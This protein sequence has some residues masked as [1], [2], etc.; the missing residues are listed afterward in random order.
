[1]MVS[2]FKIYV[3]NLMICN[4]V[5]RH[6]INN[7]FLH[8]GS[9]IASPV[10]IHKNCM[11]SILF[12][13]VIVTWSFSAFHRLFELKFWAIVRESD[14]GFGVCCQDA[15]DQILVTEFLWYKQMQDGLQIFLEEGCEDE[16]KRCLQFG[17]SF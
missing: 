9:S 11:A 16:G 13:E 1:M 17:Y 12:I 14:E 10:Y 8:E 15:I 4:F 6:E 7:G 2:L 5:F 3:R